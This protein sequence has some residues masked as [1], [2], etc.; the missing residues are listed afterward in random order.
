MASTGIL[1]FAH[2]CNSSKRDYLY[3]ASICAKTIKQHNPDISI[4]LFT[5]NKLFVSPGQQ[6]L[7]DNIIEFPFDDA[8]HLVVEDAYEK[9][10]PWMRTFLG[11]N[12]IS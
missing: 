9:I 6:E 11:N 5:R 12:R 3:S 4:S 1:I 10:I 8:G 7:Y 2:N